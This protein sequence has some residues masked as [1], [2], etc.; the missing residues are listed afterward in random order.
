MAFVFSSCPIVVDSFLLEMLAVI[1]FLPFSLVVFHWKSCR[2]G[3]RT[4][5]T[6][7]VVGCPIHCCFILSPV[8]ASTSAYHHDELG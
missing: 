2:F 1:L 5:R 8:V 4:L 3:Y 7:K 6:K